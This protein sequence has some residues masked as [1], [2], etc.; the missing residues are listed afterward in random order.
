[1]KIKAF[2][3]VGVIYSNPKGLTKVKKEDG[4]GWRQV[5]SCH[6]VFVPLTT[7]L[8]CIEPISHRVKDGGYALF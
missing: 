6:R 5:D 7:K 3:I 4:G 1:M 8:V 2:G